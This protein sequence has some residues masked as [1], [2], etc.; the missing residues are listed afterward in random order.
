MLDRGAHIDHGL[1]DLDIV[2]LRGP[3]QNRD[4][5]V[6]R[7]SAGAEL[8]DNWPTPFMPKSASSAARNAP[9]LAAP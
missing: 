7:Q 9:M 5:V 1:G 6:I 2:D 3:V 8:L 4:L